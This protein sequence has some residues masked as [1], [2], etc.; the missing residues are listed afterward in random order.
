MIS[1]AIHCHPVEENEIERWKGAFDYHQHINLAT[2][3]EHHPVIGLVFWCG[4]S[5]TFCIH[6]ERR[7]IIV[8][9]HAEKNTDGTQFYLDTP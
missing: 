6:E 5:Q 2:K 7:Q 3:K 9:G 1:L 4:I 8:Y